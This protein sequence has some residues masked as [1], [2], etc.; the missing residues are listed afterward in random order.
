MMLIVMCIIRRE[1]GVRVPVYT[2]TVTGRRSTAAGV[3]V[4]LGFKLRVTRYF[5]TGFR[6]V[7][8]GC[9]RRKH[10]F[11][12]FFAHAQTFGIQTWHDVIVY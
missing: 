2:V 1:R 6:Y 5:E 7:L 4:D 3:T 11:Y 10:C 12:I 9:L 8:I